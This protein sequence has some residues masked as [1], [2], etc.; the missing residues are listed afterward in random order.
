MRDIAG[1]LPSPPLDNDV[2]P[3]IPVEHRGSLN[4]VPEGV[5]G[6]ALAPVHVPFDNRQAPPEAKVPEPYKA[7]LDIHHLL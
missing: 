7:L 1:R 2:L 6:S 4:E 3:A 5:Q